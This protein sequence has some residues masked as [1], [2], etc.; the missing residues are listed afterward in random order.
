MSKKSKKRRR[1][2]PPASPSGNGA[3]APAEKEPKP[4]RAEA[5][6]APARRRFGERLFRPREAAVSP[7]PSLSVSL[8]RGML[9]VGSSPAILTIA[10]LTVL[11]IW[12]ASVGVARPLDPRGLVVTMGLPPIHVF[13]D[14]GIASVAARDTITLTGYVFGG[15]ILRAFVLGL[16]SL[17]IVTA[18]RD[19]RP[20]L[21][22]SLR[23]LPKTAGRLFLLLS[24]EVAMLVSVLPLL[25]GFLGP[26]FGFT[27]MMALGIYFL[28]FVPVILAA[29]DTTLADA[30][31]RSIKAARLPGPRHLLLALA[32][33][34]AIN[35]ILLITPSSVVSPA[36]PSALTW[37][38]ALLATF[39]HLAILAALSFR[40]LAVRELVPHSPPPVRRPRTRP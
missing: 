33:T 9:P 23:R 6:P 16:L 19:G 36:T 37:V 40:W 2:P 18:V 38:F 11:A 24:V 7:Y 21:R 25:Q 35:W 14:L 8:G 26:G 5:P 13:L 32:Y 15:I 22:G 1:R 30:L 10:F 31:R 4:E 34:L 3:S 28:V 27:V 39:A 17:L 29:E 12:G 20:D